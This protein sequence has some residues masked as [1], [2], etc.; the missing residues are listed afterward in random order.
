MY[1][2]KT[3][4]TGIV[5]FLLIVLF[6]F[7]YGALSGRTGYVP[8]LVI[9]TE[10]KQCV[11]TKEVMRK[12]HPNLLNTWKE[13]VVRNGDRTYRA[14]DGRT[15]TVSLTGTCMS[16]HANKA[17]FC[18]RC[19]NYASVKPYC[20]DCHNEPKESGRKAGSESRVSSVKSGAAS[21]R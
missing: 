16:C 9:R 2:A 8:E 14:K 5:V 7:L 4:I 12:E 20:W 11:E 21:K 3:V 10:A 15:Y 18:D 19:H 1:N 17:E 13:A 6:P